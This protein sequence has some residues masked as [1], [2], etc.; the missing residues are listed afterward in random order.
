[1]CDSTKMRATLK[2]EM[3][4]VHETQ[5]LTLFDRLAIVVATNPGQSLLTSFVAVLREQFAG[6][7]AVRGFIRMG[8]ATQV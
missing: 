6:Y 4:M 1:M 3:L 8:R 2:P 7:W 5:S